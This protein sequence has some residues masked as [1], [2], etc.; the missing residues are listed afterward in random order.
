MAFR[1]VGT[2]A[3]LVSTIL[4][5]AVATAEVQ[6]I[7]A[8]HTYVIGD[9]DSKEEA[10]A[11]CYVNAKRKV[12]E[13]AGVFIESSTDITNFNLSKDQI[14]SYSAAILSVE[15]V[16]EE[17]GFAN[18]VNTLTLTVQAKVD[19]E[20]VRKQLTEIASN[21][22]LQSKVDAQQQQIQQLEQQLQELNKKLGGVSASA[23]EEVRR[24]RD[25]E[26]VAYF[27]LGAER[28]DAESQL[29]LGVMYLFGKGVPKDDGQA[30]IWWR[31]AAEQGLAEAQVQLGIMYY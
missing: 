14:R 30:I 10:R 6:T 24:D 13:K 8:T 12:L 15:V 31:K 11:L 1:F 26:L 17:F 22:G 16:K 3:I 28:G 2:F 29:Y 5:A 18:G 7:T 23:G 27:R 20:D 21:K 4:T 25:K 9:R 19:L